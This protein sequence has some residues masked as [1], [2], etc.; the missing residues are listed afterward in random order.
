MTYISGVYNSQG[1]NVVATAM[2]WMYFLLVVIALAIV[3]AVLSAY[4]FYQRKDV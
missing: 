4:V 2:S 3:S 1:G